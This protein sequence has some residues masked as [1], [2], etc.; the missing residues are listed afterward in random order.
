MATL[1]YKVVWARCSIGSE[2]TPLPIGTE[3]YPNIHP[4][5]NFLLKAPRP[6]LPPSPDLCKTF[7]TK[8]G[9]GVAPPLLGFVQKKS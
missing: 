8:S 5:G 7:C 2:T 9:G 4:M 6:P 3:S 1:F